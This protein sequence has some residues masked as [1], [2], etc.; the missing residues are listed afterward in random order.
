MTGVNAAVMQDKMTS[1]TIN[2]TSEKA[3]LH[4]NT[5]IE[6]LNFSTHVSIQYKIS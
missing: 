2:S 1:V 4:L 5:N 6:Y 3:T